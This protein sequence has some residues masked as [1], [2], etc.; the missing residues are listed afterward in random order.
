[1]SSPAAC[2]AASPV[3]A[4]NALL[5]LDLAETDLLIPGAYVV[6]FPRDSNTV[7]SEVDS[8]MLA[9]KRAVEGVRIFGGVGL[10]LC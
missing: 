4:A 9:G 6:C 7:Q 2:H 10:A 3:I 1:M 8:L 5:N